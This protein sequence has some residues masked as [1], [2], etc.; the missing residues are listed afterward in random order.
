MITIF[1][2]TLR[3]FFTCGY[4]KQFKLDPS[5]IH[6]R[7]PNFVIQFERFMHFNGQLRA[8]HLILD[9]TPTYTSFQG[10]H[11]VMTVGNSLISYLDIKL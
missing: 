10:P 4:A 1:S 7:Y 6:A 8:F 5:V 9:Y 3:I 11:Q 2:W